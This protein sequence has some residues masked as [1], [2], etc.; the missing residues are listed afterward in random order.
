MHYSTFKNLLS[1]KNEKKIV[2]ALLILVLVLASVY[3]SGRMKGAISLDQYAAQV[4]ETCAIKS[5]KPACYDDIA[6]FTC[7]TSSYVW[8]VKTIVVRKS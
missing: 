2:F 3:V 4:I 8:V 1:Q 7:K 5:Y 6:C